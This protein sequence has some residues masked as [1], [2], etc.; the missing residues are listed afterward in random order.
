M[1]KTS[2]AWPG[3]ERHTSSSDAAFFIKFNIE[4]KALFSQR[5]I[6]N[7]IKTIKI[8]GLYNKHGKHSNL[9]KDDY[10]KISSKFNHND[11]WKSIKY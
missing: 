2:Y 10:I 7:W 3:Y 8:F 5:E 11:F 4:I 6:I 9:N 1:P